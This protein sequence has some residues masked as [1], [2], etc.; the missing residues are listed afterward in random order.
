MRLQVGA[1]RMELLRLKRR[2]LVARRGHKLLKDKQEQ[3]M[4]RILELVLEIKGLRASIA[5]ELSK[6]NEHFLYAQIYSEP[7]DYEEALAR[8]AYKIDL[9]LGVQSIVNVNVPK[10]NKL[11]FSGSLINYQFTGISGEL[12]I[13]LVK[14]EAL[15]YGLLNLVIRE[16]TLS[17]LAEELERTRR[18]VNALEYILI[19]NLEETIRYINMKLSEV[20][21]GNL[22]RLMRIK[23]ILER[24]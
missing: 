23:N 15:L 17:A 12:D 3:L 5:Q 22:T 21:R 13:A 6:I 20:E 8:T 18:R 10:I 9:E 1:T 11:T 4:R 2:L 7:E 19:P 24:A 14:F 16:K